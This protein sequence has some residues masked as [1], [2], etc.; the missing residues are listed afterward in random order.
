MISFAGV[1]MA[2][3]KADDRVQTAYGATKASISQGDCLGW[4]HWRRHG[5]SRRWQWLQ[6]GKG[7]APAYVEKYNCILQLYLQNAK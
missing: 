7:Y 2:F 5:L 4:E 6:Q 1:S 3:L